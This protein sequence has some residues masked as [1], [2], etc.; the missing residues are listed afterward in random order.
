MTLLSL[1]RIF[2]LLIFTAKVDISQQQYPR[3]IIKGKLVYNH[4]IL[5]S[6]VSFVLCVYND[7][8]E[9]KDIFFTIFFIMPM[10]LQIMTFC[11]LPCFTMIL[12]HM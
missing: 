11:Q 4:S 8:H 2:H 3:L 7:V 10:A 9:M 5:I 1:H 6:H 12:T